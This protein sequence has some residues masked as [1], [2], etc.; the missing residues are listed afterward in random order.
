MNSRIRQ[1]LDQ[2]TTLEDEL[3]KAVEEQ[4]ERLRYQIEGKRITFEH[5]IREAHLKARMGIFHWFLTVRPQ[6][7]LTAPIVYGMIVPLALF[8]LCISFYQLTCFPIYRVAKVRRAN[9]IMLDHQH[10]AY[11]NIIEKVD[12]MYC[13]YA[14]G[15]LGYAQ[16]ITARTEQYFCPIKHARKMLNANARYEHFLD[17]GEADNFHDKLEEFRAVLAKERDSDMTR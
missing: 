10:L 3:Q 17:Y 7:Y 12:C 16:E 4:Q 9:Y 1:I 5:T 2:I 13:S 6:N 11:L 15:L 8:D 14:V